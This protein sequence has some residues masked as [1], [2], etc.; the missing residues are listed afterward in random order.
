[1]ITFQSR[2]M[3]DIYIPIDDEGND[4]AYP[5]Y[6]VD[7]NG[8]PKTITHVR[9]NRQEVN[10]EIVV[11]FEAYFPEDDYVSPVVEPTLDSVKAE[12]L[13]K[14]AEKRWAVESGGCT[15]NGVN[16][17]TDVNSMTKILGAFVDSQREPTTW[18]VNWKTAGFAE[19]GSPTWATLNADT[20]AMIYMAT[21]EHMKLCFSVEKSKQDEVMAL[22]S[23]AEVQQWLE[24]Q[25]D[26]G[27]PTKLSYDLTL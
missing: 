27:W 5:F 25:L 12:A 21:R 8:Q 22:S 16:I 17:K 20:M 3:G 19:D 11:T 23:R 13:G 2:K 9:Q 18:S 26:L 14:L 24:T 4:V 6:I 1:M 7:E 15:W 10:G